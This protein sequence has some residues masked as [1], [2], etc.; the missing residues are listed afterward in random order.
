MQRVATKTAA[1]HQKSYVRLK[2]TLIQPAQIDAENIA[3]MRLTDNTGAHY[4]LYL[5]VLMIENAAHLR[6]LTAH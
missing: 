3:A 6:L 1:S 2:L 5:N 4:L